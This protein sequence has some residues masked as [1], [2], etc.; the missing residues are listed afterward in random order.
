MK[1]KLVN[2]TLAALAFGAGSLSAMGD[3]NN[4][5]QE[6]VVTAQK[7]SES[8]QSIP[9]AVSALTGDQL[10]GMGATKF[11]DF[12]LSAPSVSFI[13][14]GPVQDHVVMR[15]ISSG[16]SFDSQTPATGYYI[17]NVP[18][19][20]TFNSGGTDFRLFDINHVEVLR[21]PQGTLY[22]AGA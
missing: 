11:E 14:L 20:Q 13:N 19:A 4:Q 17:D 10:T 2:S 15:G 16:V 8:I 5:L 12:A 21:G 7:R 9:L 22:G 18:V 3:D 6:I 1:H